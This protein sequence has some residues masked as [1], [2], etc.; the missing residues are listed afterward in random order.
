MLWSFIENN[1]NETKHL[2]NKLTNY[3]TL[4]RARAKREK[5]GEIERERELGRHNEK[6]GK[7]C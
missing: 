4:T 1:S 5:E 3:H 7:S 6:N 2:Y